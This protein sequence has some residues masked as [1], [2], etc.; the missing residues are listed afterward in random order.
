VFKGFRSSSRIVNLWATTAEK[1][2]G[3]IEFKFNFE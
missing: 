3:C 1:N 2:F